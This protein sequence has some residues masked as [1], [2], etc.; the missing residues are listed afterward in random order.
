V[1][2]SSTPKSIENYKA[3]TIT[4]PPPNGRVQ[5]E[6]EIMSKT[7]DRSRSATIIA[8][9]Q[10]LF[11]PG[12]KR[13]AANVVADAHPLNAA[14]F[15]QSD[16]ACALICASFL[17]KAL[18]ALLLSHFIDHAE[19]TR[20]LDPEQ[21]GAIAGFHARTSVAYCLGL[22]D[23]E[24]FKNLTLVRQVRDRFAHTHQAI[25]FRDREIAGLC[26]GL[27][28]KTTK[29]TEPKGAKAMFCAVAGWT[30]ACLQQRISRIRKA[31]MR[32]DS[33][34]TASEAGEAGGPA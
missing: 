20:L 30:F 21:H 7:K 18:G 10:E 9:P 29:G 8:S 34:Y 32:P 16:Q 26:S 23:T 31:L 15:G 3:T 2:V 11:A 27:R 12:K 4:L 14:I 24:E 19:S 5:R 33:T 6:D 1:Y 25:D 13:K 28:Y 17:E 22:I